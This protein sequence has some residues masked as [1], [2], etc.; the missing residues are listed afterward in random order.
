MAK[1]ILTAAF[2]ATAVACV[3]AK[4]SY[5]SVTAH[6]MGDSCFNAGMQSTNHL[7]FNSSPLLFLA[8]DRAGVPSR[9]QGQA[10]TNMKGPSFLSRRG[11]SENHQHPLYHRLLHR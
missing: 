2:V 5:P 3:T 11:A 9:L 1:M 6:G 7:Q 10:A 8:G 4:T